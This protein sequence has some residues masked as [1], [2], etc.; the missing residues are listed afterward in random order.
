MTRIDSTPSR[1]RGAACLAIV[2]FVVAAASARSVDVVR[3]GYGV[4]QDEATYVG[5]ALSLAYDGD[6]TYERRDVERFWGLYHSGPEGIFLKRG[7]T[8]SFH[9]QRSFPFVG[10]RSGP[11]P[12]PDRLYFS[13]A[14]IY[15]VAGAPFVR[16]FGLNG[17]LLF[18]V[19]LLTGVGVCGYLFLAARSSPIAAA[20]FTTAFIGAYELLRTMRNRRFFIFSLVCYAL[21]LWLCKEVAPGSRLSGRWTD[22]AAAVLLGVATYAKPPNGLLVAPLVVLFWCRRQ[23]IRGMCVGAVAVVAAVMLFAVAKGSGS[24]I[25][26]G[27]GKSSIRLS[28]SRPNSAFETR[29]GESQRTD[30]PRKRSCSIVSCQ[31]SSR[32]TSM[33]LVGR[34]FGL[35]P[36]FFPGIVAI[37]AGS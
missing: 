5:M 20:V 37:S 19:V 32:I 28:P 8:L 7:H 18:H 2:L 31:P 26:A 4:K 11:D 22:I 24:A 15:S 12:R 16:L 3:A 13:K 10:L 6:L 17:L 25:R 27:T 14:L 30:K 9:G 29:G 23:W 1:H 36:Y 35:L 21:F 33:L 34:H